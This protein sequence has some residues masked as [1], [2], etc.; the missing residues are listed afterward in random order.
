MGMVAKKLHPSMIFNLM[1]ISFVHY[2][3]MEILD[4]LSSLKMILEATIKDIKSSKRFDS[5]DAE[6]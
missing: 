6:N 5:I 3:C 1:M 2:Y 4:F